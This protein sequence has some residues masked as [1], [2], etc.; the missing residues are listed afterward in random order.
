MKKSTLGLVA[1]VLGSAFGLWLNQWI[2]QRRL[3]K[4]ASGPAAPASGDAADY[5]R[6][7]DGII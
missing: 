7:A 1:G 6:L 5:S 3:S 2:A 4:A